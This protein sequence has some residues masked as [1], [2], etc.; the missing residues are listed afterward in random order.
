MIEDGTDRC[1][2]KRALEL[3]ISL[4]FD[5]LHSFFQFNTRYVADSVTVVFI[6]CLEQVSPYNC[7]FAVEPA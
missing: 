2:T 7:I 1:V 6:W 3:D 5:R 4:L